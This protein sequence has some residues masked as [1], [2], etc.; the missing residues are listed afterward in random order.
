MKK[1]F[2]AYKWSKKTSG[3][4]KRNTLKQRVPSDN[5]AD[6]AID[7]ARYAITYYAEGLKEDTNGII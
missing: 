1:E 7:A 5:Q 3:E 2:Q 6:H 4:Y